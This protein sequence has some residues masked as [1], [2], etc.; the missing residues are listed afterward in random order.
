MSE[1]AFIYRCLDCR[2]VWGVGFNQTLR[3]DR[4]GSKERDHL[5]TIDQLTVLLRLVSGEDEL[6]TVVEN[7]QTA[8]E[9]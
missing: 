8:V 6:A 4:C 3:C 2:R 9:E 1:P 7:W 5:A